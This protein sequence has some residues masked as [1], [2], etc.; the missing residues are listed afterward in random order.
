MEQEIYKRIKSKK[1]KLT[2][3]SQSSIAT[4]IHDDNSNSYKVKYLI[5]AALQ[6]RGL[7]HYQ[8][9]KRNDSMQADKMLEWYLRILHLDPQAAGKQNE[10][11]C[12]S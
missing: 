5:V 9:S 7:F 2:C 8:H 4:K 1:M 3:L 11:L 6:F 10:P 12:L